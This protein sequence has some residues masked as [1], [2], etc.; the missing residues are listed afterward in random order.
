M[1]SEFCNACTNVVNEI[2]DDVRTELPKSMARNL[3]VIDEGDATRVEYEDEDEGKF[4]CLSIKSDHMSISMHVDSPSASC[5][6]QDATLLSVDDITDNDGVC[7]LDDCEFMLESEI[8]LK[9]T[10]LAF[11]NISCMGFEQGTY[12]DLWRNE[13]WLM[14]FEHRVAGTGHRYGRSMF[15]E[16]LHRYYDVLSQD[17]DAQ[18]NAEVQA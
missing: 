4:L 8:C 17:I 7:H 15:I 5:D 16:A 10:L 2:V 12:E 9:A 14:D 18:R 6:M 3:V 13:L 11:F 1:K